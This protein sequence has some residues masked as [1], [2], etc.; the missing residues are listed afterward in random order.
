MFAGVLCIRARVTRKGWPKATSVVT[1]MG[2]HGKFIHDAP[3]C[4]QEKKVREPVSQRCSASNHHITAFVEP[5]RIIRVDPIEWSDSMGA[6]F[7]FAAASVLGGGVNFAKPT[8][9]RAA[10]RATWPGIVRRSG[11]RK[12][13]SCRRANRVFRLPLSWLFCASAPRRPVASPRLRARQAIEEGPGRP[14]SV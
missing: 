7:V 4:S 1:A 5:K 12:K 9:G 10:R 11:V 6:S 2:S 8:A 13:S 3:L 14:K